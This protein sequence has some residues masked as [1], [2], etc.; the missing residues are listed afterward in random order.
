M[1]S[2]R[3]F[4]SNSFVIIRL[5]AVTPGCVSKL[6]QPTLEGS[7]TNGYVYR[8]TCPMCNKV[9]VFSAEAIQP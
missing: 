4:G 3:P 1:G 2:D 5:R 8:Y 6:H 9:S 7:V